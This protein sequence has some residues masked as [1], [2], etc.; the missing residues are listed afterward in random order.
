MIEFILMLAA[1]VF[2]ALA[3]LGI[4]APRRVAW[5]AAGL[6]CWALTVL[7]ALWP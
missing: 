3:M 6:L 1:V 4:P 2:F 5:L 7:I